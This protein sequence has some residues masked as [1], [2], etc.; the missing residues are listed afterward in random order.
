L[1]AGK[2]YLSGTIIIKSNVEMQVERGAVLQ[3]SPDLKDYTVQF[4]VGALSAGALQ[5]NQAGAN[6][7]ITSER[8]ENVAFTGGGTID[9][10]GVSL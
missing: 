7:L 9:G 3:A 6:M 4:V 5:P 1:P 8:A 10:E 2:T